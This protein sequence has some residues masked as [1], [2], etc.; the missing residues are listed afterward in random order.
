MS[1]TPCL[2]SASEA[3]RCIFPTASFCHLA[4]S[5]FS[6]FYP[7]AAV[8]GD[9]TRCAGEAIETRIRRTFTAMYTK[10]RRTR[11]GS[12]GSSIRQEGSRILSNH[13][14]FGNFPRST[15]FVVLIPNIPVSGPCVREPRAGKHSKDEC[16]KSF[17]VINIKNES[18][19]KNKTEK[20]KPGKTASTMATTET[21]W[22]E[23]RHR[24]E[25]EIKAGRS[26]KSKIQLVLHRCRRRGRGR[27]RGGNDA[28]V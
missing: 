15:S 2:S 14:R 23:A 6:C 18:E 24:G 10:R 28:H 8:D 11:R 26:R 19:Q 9:A 27:G 25:A 5:S 13:S 22:D 16:R 4:V 17:L 1:E 3:L 7:P 20:K 21:V 12:E